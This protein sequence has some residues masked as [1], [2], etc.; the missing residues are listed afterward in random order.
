MRPIV[1]QRTA[2]QLAMLVLLTVVSLVQPVSPAV[3][4]EAAISVEQYVCPPCGCGVDDKIYDKPGSCP[5]CGMPLMV[6]GSQPAPKAPPQQTRKKAA[7]LIFDN[8]QIIDYTGPY[9][10]FGAAGLQVFTVATSTA[11]ITTSMGMKVTPHYAL[12][13]AP[14]ADVLLIPG[15]GIYA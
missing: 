13:D 10:V 1:F 5:V 11:M 14:A 9:E 15:G 6:K 8:V 3:R 12:E 4:A 2:K 7:I